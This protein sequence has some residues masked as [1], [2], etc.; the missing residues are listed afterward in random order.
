M[1]RTAIENHAHGATRCRITVAN[2]R[3]RHPQ[4]WRNPT[5][6]RAVNLPCSSLLL[7]Y[8]RQMMHLGFQKQPSPT[9]SN[10]TGRRL[11]FHS[12]RKDSPGKRH[13]SYQHLPCWP[14]HNWSTNS[15]CPARWHMQNQS[16]TCHGSGQGTGM[17]R[18]LKGVSAVWA[19]VGNQDYAPWRLSV[20]VFVPEHRDCVSA[21]THVVMVRSDSS[22]CR[23]EGWW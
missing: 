10:H 18:Y 21:L 3:E 23:R 16:C 13:Y 11:N 4:E 22:S 2:T 19:E 20:P 8:S 5:N 17:Y 14:V 15:S 7:K 12:T 9:S 1:C 6:V